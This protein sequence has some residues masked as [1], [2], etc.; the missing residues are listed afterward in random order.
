MIKMMSII[1]NRISEYNK[2]M[3]RNYY[4]SQ[5]KLNEVEGSGSIEEIAEKLSEIIDKI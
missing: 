4:S 5:N 3:Y 1:T 2:K